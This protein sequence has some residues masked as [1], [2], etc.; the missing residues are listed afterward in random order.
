MNCVDSCGWLE[1]FVDGE[2]AEEYAP[3]LQDYENL[4][5]PSISIYEVYRKTARDAGLKEA[6]QAI[7]TMQMGTCVELDARTA[8]MSARVGLEYNLP[9]ADS[10]F[11]ATAV[12]YDALLWTQDEHFSGLPGVK[13]IPK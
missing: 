4:I 12:L 3:V 8:I 6:S 10:I 2:N 11:Y 13:F 9:L 5:V 7:A 1:Y